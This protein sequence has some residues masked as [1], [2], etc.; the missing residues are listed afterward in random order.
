MA[1]LELL[2]DR[3]DVEEYCLKERQSQWSCARTKGAAAC[4][5]ENLALNKCA[6]RLYGFH[7]FLHASIA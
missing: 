2:A 1:S 7:I 5:T 3:Y 6:H 4:E